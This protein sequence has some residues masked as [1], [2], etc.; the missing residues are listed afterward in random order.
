VGFH[1]RL[2]RLWPE[3][4]GWRVVR[5]ERRLQLLVI[6]FTYFTYP[7]F[8]TVGTRHSM[9]KGLRGWR[10]RCLMLLRREVIGELGV[11]IEIRRVK[12]TL[13]GRIEVET[14]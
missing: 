2:P 12:G 3:H 10:R 9:D 4:A 11:D 5:N 7:K 6:R 8:N 14:V 13:Q 1:V